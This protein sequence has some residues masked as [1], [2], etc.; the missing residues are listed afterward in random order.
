MSYSPSSLIAAVSPGAGSLGQIAP[1]TDAYSKDSTTGLTALTNAEKFISNAIG[2]VTI[3]GGLFFL[4][5]FFMGALNWITSGGEKGK[6]EKARGEM[7]N[8]AIGMI[9]LVASYGVIGLVG[10]LLGFNVLDLKGQFTLLIPGAA[11]TP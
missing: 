7:T 8:G 6:V 1:V 5:Y 4:V 10:S 2:A 3:L 9:I 11:P